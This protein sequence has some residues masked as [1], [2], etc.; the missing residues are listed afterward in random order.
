MR[1]I[2][3]LMKLAAVAAATMLAFFLT[4]PIALYFDSLMS[5]RATIYGERGD[6]KISE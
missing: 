3:F 6:E 5:V 2:K 1:K 4:L